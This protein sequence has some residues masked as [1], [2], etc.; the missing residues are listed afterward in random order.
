MPNHK[1]KGIVA[2]V[3]HG[4]PANVEAEESEGSFRPYTIKTLQSNPKFRSIFNHF[5]FI[6]KA[7]RTTIESLMSI[8]T[9][10]GVKCFTTESHASRA[11]LETT[12][13]ITF[14]DEDMEVE[15]LDH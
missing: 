4:N 5:G 13:V 15:Y 6:L 11:F 8:A 9:V 14:K 12:N 7:R 10:A 2:V 3:I 1:G